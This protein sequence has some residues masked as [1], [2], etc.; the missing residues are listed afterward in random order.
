MKKI[1][2][3]TIS[4]IFLLSSCA[5][6]LD[7]KPTNQADS[8]TSI[9]T[10]TD[11][12][13]MMR[14]LMRNMTSG[15]YY[16]RN[17]FLYADAKGGDYC[18]GSRGRGY[19]NLFAF[20]HSP[21]LGAYGTFW[22][23][24]Y[25]C[26]VQI[27]N[28]ITNIDAITEA[29]NGS[30]AFNHVKAQALTARAICYYDLVRLYGKP[31]D[32]DKG[33]LGV[34]LILEVPDASIQP[35]RNTVEQIYTQIITDLTTG[36]SL[37]NGKAKTNGFINYYANIAMQARVYLQMQNYTAALT[38]AEEIINSNVYVLY[39]NANWLTSWAAQFQTESIFELSMLATEGA[40]G[41]GSLGSMTVRNQ[42]GITSCEYF[43]M[44]TLNTQCH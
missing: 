39:T 2:L 9:V 17:M 21:D 24:I 41:T 43:I 34:P 19:D 18:V 30:A 13:V 31:Y 33:S 16:G 35:T 36:A 15:N 44:N 26:L 25:N 20:D 7:V 10:V 22:N 23:T 29:G 6:F 38:A 12:Q 14:G 27:N 37:F 42:S 3:Y 32:M 11:A 40:L 8:K 28:I 1:V 5:D 4:C